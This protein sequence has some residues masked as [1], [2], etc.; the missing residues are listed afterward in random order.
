MFCEFE[1]HKYFEKVNKVMKP[2]QYEIHFNSE[3]GKR[4][5]YVG[6]Q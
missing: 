4:T 2:G 6:A 5:V 3:E 1:I